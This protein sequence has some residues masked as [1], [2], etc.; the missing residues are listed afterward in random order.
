MSM[1]MTWGKG[2][3]KKK[4]LGRGQLLSQVFKW[5]KYRGYW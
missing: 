1:V 5:Q 2:V 3:A 4:A